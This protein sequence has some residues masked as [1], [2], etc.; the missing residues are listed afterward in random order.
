M[1]HVKTGLKRQNSS[2]INNSNVILNSKTSI[3]TNLT[4]KMDSRSPTPYLKTNQSRMEESN[5]KQNIYHSNKM[6]TSFRDV[7]QTESA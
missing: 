3:Q 2:A 6:M 4:S 1:S 7:K 5:R